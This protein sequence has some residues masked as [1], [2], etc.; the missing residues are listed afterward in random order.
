MRHSE[1]MDAGELTADR[2]EPT[3]EDARRWVRDILDEL[4]M[5]HADAQDFWEAYMD[6][7]GWLRYGTH[8]VFD[9]ISNVLDIDPM[10]IAEALRDYLRDGQ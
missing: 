1:T 2:Y 3:D 9:A 10:R 5:S 7:E 8:D 6:P 4:N